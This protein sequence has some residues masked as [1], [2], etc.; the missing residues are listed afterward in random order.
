MPDP[1]GTQGVVPRPP[2]TDMDVAAEGG[3]GLWSGSNRSPK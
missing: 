3:P 2:S 1:L